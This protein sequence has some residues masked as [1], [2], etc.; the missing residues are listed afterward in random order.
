[1][2]YIDSRGTV[3][4]KFQ[5]V[6]RGWGLGSRARKSRIDAMEAYKWRAFFRGR[7]YWQERRS[8]RTR[9]RTCKMAGAKPAIK[10][11][12]SPRPCSVSHKDANAMVLSCP[13]AYR[14]LCLKPSLLSDSS[15]RESSRRDYCRF[16]KILFARNHSCRGQFKQAA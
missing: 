14:L 1:M 2:R 11:A 16:T 6:R 5:A 10:S 12:S 3:A 4:L 9:C 7:A 8:V 15:H 13:T